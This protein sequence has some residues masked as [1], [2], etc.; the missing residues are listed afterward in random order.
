MYARTAAASGAELAVVT[1]A[2]CELETNL[3]RLLI[4]HSARPVT[5]HGARDATGQSLVS[6][7][8][9][10]AAVIRLPA[11]GR[12]APHTHSGHPILVVAGGQGTI[13]YHGRIYPPRAG[14]TY[15]IAGT[16]P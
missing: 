7:G 12:L 10:G 8:A 2:D 3:T 14:N 13:T 1:W 16:G 4:D 5:M 15:L 9:I 11:G 6:N